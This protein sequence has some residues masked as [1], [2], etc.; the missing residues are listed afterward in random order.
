MYWRAGFQGE[1]VWL[2]VLVGCVWFGVFGTAVFVVRLSV[3]DV[4]AKLVPLLYV[5]AKVVLSGVVVWFVGT[6]IATSQ[7]S[8][9]LTEEGCLLEV[10]VLMSKV[11]HT[12]MP[13]TMKTR[14]RIKRMLVKLFF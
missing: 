1:C 11:F 5:R 14:N 2:D 12:P 7:C 3:L 9:F 8:G 4:L 6:G 10:C 13:I